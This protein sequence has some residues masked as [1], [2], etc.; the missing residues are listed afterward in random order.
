MSNSQW[1]EHKVN[2]GIGGRRGHERK[3]GANCGYYCCLLVVFL[4]C[5]L[6]ILPFMQL[7][8]ETITLIKDNYE[9][10]IHLPERINDTFLQIVSMSNTFTM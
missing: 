8:N 2:R 7:I 10:I 5:E 3:M 6:E 4:N 9:F 1:L